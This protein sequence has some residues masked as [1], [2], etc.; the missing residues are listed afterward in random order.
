MNFGAKYQTSVF[1]GLYRVLTVE[2]EFKGGQFTQTLD[3]IRIPNQVDYDYIQKPRTT[4]GQRDGSAS[5][6]QIPPTV[7]AAAS[8]ATA[9]KVTSGLDSSLPQPKGLIASAGSQIGK[10]QKDLINI[11]RTAAE[12]PISSATALATSAQVQ[13]QR[14]LGGA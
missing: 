2:S 1:S 7:E 4:V 13:A 12:S 5:T 14:L 6:V 8:T 3:L 9:N 11:N 10:L